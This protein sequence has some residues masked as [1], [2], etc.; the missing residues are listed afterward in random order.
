MTQKTRMLVLIDDNHHEAL[1]I[2]GALQK[3]CKERS[4]AL[5]IFTDGDEALAFIQ[6]E[7]G[8]LIEGAV[9]DLWMVDKKTGLENQ[10]KGEEIIG[11]LLQRHPKA[12]VVVLSAHM[13][14]AAR[15][16]F[17]ARGIRSINKPATAREVF[18]AVAGER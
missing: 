12:R 14:E 8:A 3:I 5:R 1:S 13:N 17:G 6:G 15:E 10:K 11:V 16:S 7:Q 2:G 18:E 4:L 9:V